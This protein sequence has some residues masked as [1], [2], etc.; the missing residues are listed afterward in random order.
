MLPNSENCYLLGLILG[1]GEISDE[2]FSINLPFNKWGTDP[3]VAAQISRDLLTRI[4]PI[5]KKIYDLDVDYFRAGGG[6]WI[7]RSLT[8]ITPEQIEKIKHD[9][10]TLGLPT[11]GQLIIQADL[12]TARQ[13]LSGQRAELL[14]S[15]VFDARASIAESHRRFT[16]DAP[17]VSIEIPGRGN[18]FRLVVQLCS[19]LTSLGSITDQILYNHPNQHSS[20][21]P[22]YGN[23]RK[24]FKIRILA[25]SFLEKHSFA[26][27]SFSV[28]AT[29]LA[30]NQKI[31][32]QKPCLHRE[33]E[34]PGIK[35]IHKDIDSPDLPVEVRNKMFL[36]YFHICAAMGCPFAPIDEV[37]ALVSNYAKYISNFPTLLKGEYEE[38]L[39][40]YNKIAV[41]YFSKESISSLNMKIN[42]VMTSFHGD[43]YSSLKLAV[44]YLVDNDLRGKRTSGKAEDILNK[45]QNESIEVREFRALEGAPLFVA[46]KELKRAAIISSA[47]SELNQKALLN[48]IEIV[49]L[50]INVK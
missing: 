7:V 32:N 37:R 19:W 13:L 3:D 14:L 1:G 6:D 29:E 4:R 11:S 33:I 45:H 39:E 17:I 9:L 41:D 49:G 40:K 2:A 43:G 38:V 36:H 5:F 44:A 46:N 30:S 24:G 10:E 12:Q 21:D 50:D 15:G 27:R 18:N 47:V 8:P 23:W 34:S 42:S 26:M 28:G 25:K 20:K 48:R 16:E 22:E 31:A 35:V